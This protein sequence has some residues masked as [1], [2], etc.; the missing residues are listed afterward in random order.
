MVVNKFNIGLLS[1]HMYG[2]IIGLA[3]VISYY[4]A[5]KIIKVEN[6]GKKNFERGFWWIVV[7][8]IIGARVYHVIDY[9]KYYQEHLIEIIHVWNGGLGIYGAVLG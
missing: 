4:V 6:I 1:F 2:L 9:W 8:G 7:A 3:I 5:E